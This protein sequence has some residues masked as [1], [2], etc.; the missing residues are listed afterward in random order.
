MTNKIKPTK[1]LHSRGKIQPAS[2]R[3]GAQQNEKQEAKNENEIKD[4][5]QQ[6]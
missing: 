3:T 2:H 4:Q 1:L 6:R 5:T